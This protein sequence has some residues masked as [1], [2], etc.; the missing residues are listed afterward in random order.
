MC[1][2]YRATYERAKQCTA[3][4]LGKIEQ[5]KF[6]TKTIKTINVKNKTLCNAFNFQP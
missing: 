6:L 5:W 2:I 3:K 4:T 1:K